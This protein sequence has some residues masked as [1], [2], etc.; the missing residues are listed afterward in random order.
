MPKKTTKKTT[1]KKVSKKKVAKKGAARRAKKTAAKK[2]ATR[3]PL[4]YIRTDGNLLIPASAAE[5]VPASKLRKGLT[6][7]RDEINRMLDDMV[8]GMTENYVIS[9]IELAAS[10]SADGKFMGF[11][12]G[13]A[14][15]IKITVKPEP[16]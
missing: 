10:F 2:K 6:S 1:K 11:G 3:R 8:S 12:V 4:G 9:E 15:T 16:N 5:P 13:G 7:A 14:T